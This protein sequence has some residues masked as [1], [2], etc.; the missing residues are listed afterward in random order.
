MKEI[1]LVKKDLFNRNKISLIEDKI[2]LIYDIIE[3]VFKCNVYT[4]FFD[5][6]RENEV[7]VEIELINYSIQDLDDPNLKLG[8][9]IIECD[10]NEK[11]II[12][13]N[14]IEY[15]LYYELPM[16]WLFMSNDKIKDE[17]IKCLD[18]YREKCIDIKDKK[19]EKKFKKIEKENIL[20]ESAKEKIEKSNLSD[21]E[22][23]IYFNK[24]LKR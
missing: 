12:L 5:G 23:K 10:S 20:L 18:L 7:G 3:N 13:R 19:L 6:A 14:D 11:L 1:K 22:I 16:A 21:A 9:I 4:Y 17:M 24:V 8:N 15:N 2:R